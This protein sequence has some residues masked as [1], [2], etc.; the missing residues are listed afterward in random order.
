[1]QN[2]QIEFEKV[3]QVLLQIVS[4]NDHATLNKNF[5]LLKDF[6]QKQEDNVII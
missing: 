5:I 4:A 3:K 1:M 2:S 6:V